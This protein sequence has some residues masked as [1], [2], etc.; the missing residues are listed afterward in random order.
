[1]KNHVTQLMSQGMAQAV[2]RRPMLY[3]GSGLLRTLDRLGFAVPPA[4]EALAASGQPLGR[5]GFT[6]DVFDLDQRLKLFDLTLEQ[7]MHFKTALV[8]CGLLK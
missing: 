2:R 8:R 3:A 6:L 1:M 7:R 4:V 5:A